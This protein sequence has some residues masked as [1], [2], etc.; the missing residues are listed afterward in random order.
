M[1]TLSVESQALRTAQH[2]RDLCAEN[3]CSDA[4][5]EIRKLMEIHREEGVALILPFLHTETMP[6]EVLLT[7]LICTALFKARIRQERDS[8]F[9]RVAGSLIRRGLLD[10]AKDLK[11]LS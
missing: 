8:Y 7:P 5:I 3:K 4:V 9:D 11:G 2:I 10:Q 6:V 1:P